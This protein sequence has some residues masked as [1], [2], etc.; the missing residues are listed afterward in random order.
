MASIATEQAASIRHREASGFLPFG[1]VSS[2]SIC[3][4][5]FAIFHLPFS[6]CHFPFAIA[7]GLGEAANFPFVSFHLVIDRG[8]RS[9][10]QK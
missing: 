10:P 4:F 1:A 6:I 2:F 7:G 5:P 3:H 9:T 8:A